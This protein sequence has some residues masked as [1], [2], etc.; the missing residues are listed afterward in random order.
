VGFCRE[1][2]FEL[3]GEGTTIQASIGEK[4]AKSFEGTKREIAKRRKKRGTNGDRP[5]Q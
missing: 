5:F 2:L 4:S 1:I 3:R